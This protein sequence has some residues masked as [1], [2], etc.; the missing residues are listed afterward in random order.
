MRR[1]TIVS[2]QQLIACM[3]DFF[4]C[5]QKIAI[6][7]EIN[8]R[9]SNELKNLS[10]TLNFKSHEFHNTLNPDNTLGNN[11]IIDI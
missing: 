9:S 7:N 4:A 5:D 10:P 8:T 1:T 2:E 11:N 6:I 3:D